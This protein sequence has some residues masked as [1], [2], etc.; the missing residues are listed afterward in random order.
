MAENE[1][2]A[3]DRVLDDEDLE[4]QAALKASLESYTY[5]PTST[6]STT[7]TAVG[8]GNAS[9]GRPVPPVIMDD[10][11]DA[12]YYVDDSDD[13][14]DAEPVEGIPEEEDDE[15]EEDVVVPPVAQLPIDLDEVRRKRMER[16]GG[17]R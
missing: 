5:E 6:A 17:G 12:D 10:D 13:D 1:R 4:L 9:T 8:S 11:D 16:F 7:S 3:A 14:E 2:L 15:E